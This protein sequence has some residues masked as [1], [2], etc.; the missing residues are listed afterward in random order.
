MGYQKAVGI[1]VKK[2]SPGRPPEDRPKK[3]ELQRLYVK[4]GRSIREIASRLECSKDLIARALKEY[5]IT[6]RSNVR[7][8]MLYQYSLQE[9]KEKVR[10]EGIRGTARIVGVH[11]ATLRYHLKSRKKGQKT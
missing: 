4:E 11:E 9:L 10:K 3:S 2:R 6:A 1:K 5:G 7:S 8:S